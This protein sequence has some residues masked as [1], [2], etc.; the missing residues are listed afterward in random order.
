MKQRFAQK[1]GV[2]A[3]ANIDEVLEKILYDAT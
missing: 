3:V 2:D 1:I